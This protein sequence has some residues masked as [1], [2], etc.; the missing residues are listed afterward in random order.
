[1]QR[2]ETNLTSLNSDCISL[3]T[4]EFELY[5]VYEKEMPACFAGYEPADCIL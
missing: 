4:H 3:W 5:A 1:M 2:E